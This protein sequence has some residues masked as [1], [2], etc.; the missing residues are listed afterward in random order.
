[1]SGESFPSVV[2][3]KPN[4]TAVYFLTKHLNK[5]F[6]RIKF[7]FLGNNSLFEL[8]FDKC[9]KLKNHNFSTADKKRCGTRYN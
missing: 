9:P 1:M 5:S 2:L 7:D 8:I 4:L 6:Q 3:P